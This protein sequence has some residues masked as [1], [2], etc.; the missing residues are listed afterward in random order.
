MERELTLFFRDGRVGNNS[1]ERLFGT[2]AQHLNRGYKVHRVILPKRPSG[3]A[4]LL[5]N[6]LHARRH[7]KGIC[8]VTGDA[9]YLAAFLP[10]TRTVLTIHDVGYLQKL[11]G[12]RRLIYKWLWYKIPCWRAGRV[13]VISEATRD[14]LE[15]A[16]GD[17]GG[18]LSVVDNCAT[19]PVRPT[20]REF[21]ERRPR[22]LQIGSGHHKNLS[23]LIK[24]VIGFSCELKIVGKISA[25]DREALQAQQIPFSNEWAVSDQ[26]LLEIFHE[27]DILFFASLHEGFGL[28]ILEANAVGIPV[29]TSDRMSMPHVAGEAAVFV[30]PESPTDIRAAL[31]RLATD[32]RL[33]DQLIE[34]G[35]ANLA[36]FA[37]STVAD[38]Y[39]SVY[40]SLSK[41]VQ[42]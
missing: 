22:I 36:R 9:H 17:L 40:D 3:P 32:S 38:R 12:V 10:G 37:P 24:A 28:P 21:D 25:A 5:T 23:N 15:E 42:S 4:A 19:I 6:V 13:T 41:G 11:R 30:D 39:A 18:K 29:V 35:W 2:L 16:V 8:H 20:P 31:G 34:A 14:A 26:R 7:A 27:C 1:I 33:R